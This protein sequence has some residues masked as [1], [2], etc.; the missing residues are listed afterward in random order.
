MSC[1]EAWLHFETI[2]DLLFIAPGVHNRGRI[3]RGEIFELKIQSL[4]ESFSFTNPK[5]WDDNTI[6]DRLPSPILIYPFNS[7]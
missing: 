2:L 1:C 7:Y 6:C 4:K 3:K 5:L